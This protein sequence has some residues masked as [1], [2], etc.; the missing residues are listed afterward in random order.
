M[1]CAIKPTED[2]NHVKRTADYDFL[3]L[4]HSIRPKY[5][6]PLNFS[7]VE[8]GIY[9]SGFPMPINYPYLELLGLKTVIYLGD[10]ENDDKKKNEDISKKRKNP[11]EADKKD[12]YDIGEITENYKRW[13]SSTDVQFHHL[14]IRT[15]KEP[16]IDKSMQLQANT[17]LATALQLI[18]DRRNYPMLIHSNKGK[19]RIGVLI[20]LVRKLFQG[21]CL[22]G[23][24]EE[25]NKFAMGKSDL[26]LEFI[27]LWQPELYVDDEWKP[28]FLRI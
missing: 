4:E 1:E 23:I 19:H 6:P 16:F 17:S 27:E 5:V 8:D 24:F 28:D 9:R 12:E 11:G 22:S 14:E 20:G 25:Y 18:L 7:L 15:P 26:D 10:V 21:W 3:P 2:K 13:I